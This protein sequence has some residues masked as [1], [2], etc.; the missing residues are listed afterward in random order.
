MTIVSQEDLKLYAA[1]VNSDNSD[2]GG[3]LSANIRLS[4]I[5]NNIFP[6]IY[7]SERL[8]GTIKYRKVFWKVENIS[9]KPLYFSRVVISRAT[10]SED[11]VTM[12]LG[13]QRNTQSELILDTQLRTY[14]SAKLSS[15]ANIGS[16]T[17]LAELES[18]DLIDTFQ[19]GDAIWIGN[20][21]T[22]EIHENVNVTI[23]GTSV[24]IN[25]DTGDQIVNTNYAINNSYVCAIMDC[26]EITTL[27]S[28]VL[29]TAVS[30]VYDETTYPIL[31][32]N[33]GTIEQDWTITMVNTN[34]FTCSGHKI[35][36]IGVGSIDVNFTP[37]NPDFERPYFTLQFGGWGGSWISGDTFK[38]TTHP[39]AIPIWIKNVIPA[40]CTVALNNFELFLIGQSI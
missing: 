19:N 24:T 36:N 30:G 4:S 28:S 31:L 27:F 23:E 22:E 5:K 33:I 17:I 34:Q 14:S 35:G 37:V 8:A 29:T 13:T 10:N 9:N 25:L 20:D 3:L 18:T 1:E 11:Y 15:P 12:M 26:G 32:D 6:D 39:A 40:G 16:T 7:E 21:I 38:F 2:N